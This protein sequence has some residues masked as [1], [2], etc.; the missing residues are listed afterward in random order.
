MSSSGTLRSVAIVGASLAGL[1]AAEAL[2]KRGFDGSITMIGEEAHRPYDRPPLSKHLLKGAWEAERVQLRSA[3]ALEELQLDWRLGQPA[4]SLDP[5]ARE[6]V[7]ASGATVG[8]DAVLIA[9]GTTPRRMADPRQLS[10]VHTLRTLEDALSIRSALDREPR[11]VVV[12]GGFIGAEVAAEARRRGLDVTMVEAL[13]VPLSRG[14]GPRMG[15]VCA[16]LHVR[17]GVDVRCGVT[18][19]GFSGTDRL[20]GVFLSDGTAVAADLAVVGIGS[21][22]AV[23]WLEGSGLHLDDGVVCDR[24]CRASAPGVY[25]AGDVARW[26]NELFAVQTRVEHWTNAREQ[27]TAAVE[28]MVADHGAGDAPRAYA[29]VPYVWSDQYGF[30][31]QVA[32]R[33][34]A[35]LDAVQVVHHDS[36]KDSLLAL[37]RDGDTLV[38]ALAINASKLFLPYRRMIADRARWTDTLSE[39][40][41]A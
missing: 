17:E 3:Q 15:Q 13:P 25:A 19:S 6:V 38:G 30:R 40:G 33:P 2:R 16:D 21:V 9:T 35:H 5:A 34:S 24:F 26:H 39:A 31:I 27:A 4:V 28:T 10:G 36:A 12:G 7:L 32:G 1:T 23:D 29:P 37:Y 18:V 8:Y 11:V 20:D 14:L 22:P 41:A